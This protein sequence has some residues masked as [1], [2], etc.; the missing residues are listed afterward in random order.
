MF[1]ICVA[2]PAELLALTWTLHYFGGML[3]TCN[4]WSE[5][6][7][8][9]IILSLLAFSQSDCEHKCSHVYSGTHM[10]SGEGGG[11]G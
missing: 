2:L 5:I 10:G 4:S 3:I 9:I 7:L 6:K 11:L 1:L 8:S